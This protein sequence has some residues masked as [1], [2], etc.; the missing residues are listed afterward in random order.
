M[1]KLGFCWVSTPFRA[2][3]I[4]IFGMYLM[5]G[6]LGNLSDRFRLSCDTCYQ[7]KGGG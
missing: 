7:F 6:S 2:G 5:Q 4:V 3:D 1:E